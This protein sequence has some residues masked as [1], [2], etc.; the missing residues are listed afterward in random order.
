MTGGDEFDRNWSGERKSCADG[1]SR[2]EEPHKK[3]KTYE[4]QRRLAYSSK[5]DTISLYW[6]SYCDLLSASL[7][8]TG[9]AR[10]IVLGTSHAY[11]MYADAMQGI[12]EDTF[13]DDKG[14]IAKDRLKKKKSSRAQESSKGGYSKRKRHWTFYHHRKSFSLEGSK[15]S[16][17]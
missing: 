16:S 9:R 4:T 15:A 14:N 10:R 7:R 11:A 8:E 3:L 6:K 13:L 5:L 1:K 17:K 12:Y 2:Q